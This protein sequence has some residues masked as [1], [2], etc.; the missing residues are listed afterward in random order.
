[1]FICLFVCFLFFVFFSPGWSYRPSGP[2]ISWEGSLE[3]KLKVLVP[4]LS[5]QK[6]WRATR[7]PP[8]LIFFP[9]SPDQ[10]FE[11]AILFSMVENMI[12]MSF[13]MTWS[14][15]VPRGRAESYELYSMLTYSIGYWE[16]YRLFQRRFFLVGGGRRGSGAIWKDLSMKEV[17]MGEGTLLWRGR[18]TSQHYLK[19][20]QKFNIKKQLFQLQ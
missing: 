14:P 13:R 2:R 17:F 3:R 9:K 5:D 20:D 4:F 12:K 15:K 10:N 16:V 18:R 8:T 6:K 11:I 19:Q 1:M 7:P